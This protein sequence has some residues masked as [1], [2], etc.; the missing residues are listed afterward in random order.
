MNE[1]LCNEILVMN[2]TV[3]ISKQHLICFHTK[4]VINVFLD[5]SVLSLSCVVTNL[6]GE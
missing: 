2:Y 3:L 5:K 6:Q 1:I 4:Y